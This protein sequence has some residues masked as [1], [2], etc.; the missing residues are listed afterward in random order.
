MS[1]NK[2][3]PNDQTKTSSSSLLLNDLNELPNQQQQQ[4]TVIL[5][6]PLNQSTV[7]MNEFEKG[8]DTHITQN[9]EKTTQNKYE[10]IDYHWFYTK[11]LQEKLIWLPLSLKDSNKLEIFF[12]QNR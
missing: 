9:D 12:N 1:S 11:N 4:E 3:L 6:T 5:Q 10:S 8:I 7:K 2:A